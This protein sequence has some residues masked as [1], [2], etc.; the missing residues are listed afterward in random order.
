MIFKEDEEILQDPIVQI[1][2]DVKRLMRG[3]VT[4]DYKDEC[5]TVFGIILQAVVELKY[6]ENE[7][8]LS[9]RLYQEPSSDSK[10][11]LNATSQAQSFFLNFEHIFV[12]SSEDIS[13]LFSFYIIDP[14][15]NVEK[16]MLQNRNI[17]DYKELLNS[18]IDIFN[19]NFDINNGTK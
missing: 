19:S 7:Q 5:E 11:N 3:K 2:Q 14:K 18:A 4:V 15:E 1:Y 17:N 6:K 16:I 9:L 10:E 8:Y 13:T 12:E